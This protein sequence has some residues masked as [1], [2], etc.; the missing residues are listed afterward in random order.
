MSGKQSRN[1]VDD[2]RAKAEEKL[3]PHPDPDELSSEEARRLVHELRVHQIE[4]E[5]QNDTLREAQAELVES[6]SRYADLYDF[7]PVGYLTLDEN[8]IILEANRTLAKQLGIE[9]GL[10]IGLAFPNFIAAS[11][12][13]AFRSHVARIFEARAQ[14]SFETRLITRSNGREFYTLLTCM[15]VEDARG[16]KQCRVSVTDISDRRRAEEAVKDYMK[17]LEQSN[18]ELQDFA[19]IASHDLQEPL[20]KVQTFGSR[21]LGK[22]AEALGD[23]GGDY[24]ERMMKA[25]RRMSEMVQGLLDYSRVSTMA[26]PV[27]TIDLTHLVREVASDLEILIEKSGAR[28]EVGRLPTLEADYQQMRRLF[29]NI[30]GNAL[31]FHGEEQ[32]KPVVK[33]YAG[34]AGKGLGPASGGKTHRICVEDNGIGFDEK[35]LERIF[36]LFQRLNGRAA[37]EGTGM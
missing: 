35:Y 1:G 30:I 14:Q 23:Q 27:E 25:S 18:R 22:Y 4:L 10:L 11:E 2:L 20:R 15:F 31:K 6:N 12:R 37:F 32:P 29:Q 13:A 33:V 16:N 19:F 36:T 26:K 5:M 3:A 21:I 34:S 28:I 7:T 9:R 17:K 24:L 8:S